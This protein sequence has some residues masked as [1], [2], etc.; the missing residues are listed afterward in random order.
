MAGIGAVSPV[1]FFPHFAQNFAE[2]L[3]SK[4]QDVHLTKEAVCSMIALSSSF[5]PQPRQ[6]LAP[7]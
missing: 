6:N 7:S 2:T 4:P 3:L 1:I 5:A